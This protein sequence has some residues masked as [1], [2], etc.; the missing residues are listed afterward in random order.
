MVLDGTMKGDDEELSFISLAALTANVT[1]YLKLE[2][3]TD[4][5]EANPKEDTPER[6]DQH[7]AFIEHRLREL[8]N[9]ERR[10]R[11]DRL[12]KKWKRL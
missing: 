3:N 9:W 12:R 1:R 11:Q 8:A 5:D 10:I 7:R 6:V 2:K 4:K